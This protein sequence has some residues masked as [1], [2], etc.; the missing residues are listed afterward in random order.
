MLLMEGG[1]LGSSGIDTV[2][3]YRV[4]CGQLIGAEKAA[5]FLEDALI[6]LGN[7]R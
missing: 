3:Q 1:G 7:F 2:G 6:A 5:G 4:Q